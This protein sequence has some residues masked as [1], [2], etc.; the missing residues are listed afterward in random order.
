MKLQQALDR[1]K[2]V[3][4]GAAGLTTV[5]RFSVTAVSAEVS[6]AGSQSARILLRPSTNLL[7]GARVA[8]F[9]GGTMS[10]AVLLLEAKNGKDTLHEIRVTRPLDCGTF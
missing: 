1:K 3:V 10:A 6:Q 4:L 5:G 2:Q 7:L 8:R 9:A